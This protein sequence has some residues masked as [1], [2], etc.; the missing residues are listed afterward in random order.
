[1]CGIVAAVSHRDIVPILIEG[2]K[3]L[4]YRGYDSCGVAVQRDGELRRAR[5]TAR[6]AE[7]AASAAR[8]GISATT[9]IAH[10]RWATHGAPGGA[11]R[12]P[13]LLGRP[14][15]RR[16]QHRFRRPGRH[17]RRR[18]HRAHRP[19]AQRHHREPRR[20]ARRTEARGYVFASQTDT[21]VIAHLVHHLYDGDLLD[22]VQRAVERLR[23]AYAIAVFCRDE[24]HRVVGAREG[25]PLVLG[26]GTGEHGRALPGQRR[27]GAGRRDRPDRL[28]GRRRRRRPAD[29]ARP[30]SARAA[31]TAAT[32]RCSARCARCRRTAAPPSWAPTATTCRRRSSSSPRDRRHA[33]RRAGHQPR[34]LRR[35]CLPHLRRRSTAC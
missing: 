33:G 14:G 22:A 8:D 19:G 18:A 29:R 15:R 26:V 20:T 28:P 10:T 35:R 24:P 34:A 1:M 23:G 17:R 6:V 21:E 32:S 9:G 16:R 30:G 12:A 13:A 5:S 31:P 2:L 3:R 11:Q 25:S 4:E 27:D 7:L